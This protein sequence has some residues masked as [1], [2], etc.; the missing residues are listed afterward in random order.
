[1]DLKLNFRIAG[2]YKAGSTPKFC[3]GF[4]C[5]EAIFSQQLLYSFRPLL[6]YALKY[7]FAG[8]SDD[9]ARFILRILSLV[10]V[11]IATDVKAEAYEL[12][13]RKTTR[14]FE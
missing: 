9:F 4:T 6:L 8:G 12:S 10:S 13:R 2:T 1:M 3:D 11:E 7:A 5:N 14:L